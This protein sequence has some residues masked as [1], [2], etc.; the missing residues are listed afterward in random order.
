MSPS[1]S[2]LPEILPRRTW[3]DVQKATFQL[4]KPVLRIFSGWNEFNGCVFILNCNGQRLG[5][6]MNPW[7]NRS[8]LHFFNFSKSH[9]WMTFRAPAVVVFFLEFIS[10]YRGGC[11]KTW[12]RCFLFVGK[13]GSRHFHKFFQE[14]VRKWLKNV[15]F[16]YRFVPIQLFVRF[17]KLHCLLLLEEN[18]E[19]IRLNETFCTLIDKKLV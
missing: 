1:K 6:L 18:T 15:F 2:D 13:G 17:K 5:G 12:K 11:C 14:G 16:S 9:H 7:W 19:D 10:L 4:Y 3:N 8:F